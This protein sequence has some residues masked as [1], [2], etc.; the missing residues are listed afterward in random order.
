MNTALTLAA[1]LALSQP[2]P[3]VD[4]LVRGGTVVTM[5]TERR[6]L[7]GGTVAVLA[8]R[9]EGIYAAGSSNRGLASSFGRRY[10][11]AERSRVSLVQL[12]IDL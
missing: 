11:R 2:R 9:I 12:L 1:L 3:Q 5:D 6:V 8:N 7:E 4:L 10:E